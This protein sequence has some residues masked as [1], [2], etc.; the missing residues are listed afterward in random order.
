MR[1]IRRNLLIAAGLFLAG[2]AAQ[3]AFGRTE[4]IKSA[5]PAF[6]GSTKTAVEVWVLDQRP[7]V[8]SGGKSAN[9]VGVTRGGF[10]NPFDMTTT[11]RQALAQDL[12]SAISEGLQNSGVSAVI[13]SEA[14]VRDQKASAST[15][16]LLLVTLKQWKSDTYST[17][18]FAYE[19]VG[20]L[21]DW[22]GV[23]LA[24]QTVSGIK[25][26]SSG[27]DGGRQVLTDLL[28][29]GPLHQALTD[30]K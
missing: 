20:A 18:S 22:Q 19:L 11:S 5:W 16:R 28:G 6:N 23:L 10:G 25:N 13:A 14:T 30:Q 26:T 8:M 3:V 12:D 17:T 27:V 21:Y 4:D 2:C 29:D 24:S 9:F 7:Y 15:K 1:G